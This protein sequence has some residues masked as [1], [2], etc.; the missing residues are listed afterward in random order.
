MNQHEMRIHKLFFPIDTT[1]GRDA[2]PRPAK[3]VLTP[4]LRFQIEK[5]L[6]VVVFTLI[7]IQLSS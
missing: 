7:I 6:I 4:V 1:C 5:K 2:L 3:L